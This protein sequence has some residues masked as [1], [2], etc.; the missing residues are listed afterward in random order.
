MAF[1]RP[2]IVDSESLTVKKVQAFGNGLSIRYGSK[3]ELKEAI[4]YLK[5]NPLIAREMGERGRSI[6][7]REFN[8]KVMSDRLLKAYGELNM[9]NQNV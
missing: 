7:L 4:R 3:D 2:I 5:D 8:M 9:D 6:Y 1:G